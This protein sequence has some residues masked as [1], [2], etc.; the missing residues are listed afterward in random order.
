MPP[1]QGAEAADQRGQPGAQG[2]RGEA[3]GR[4][5]GAIAVPGVAVYSQADGLPP[6]NCATPAAA[7]QEFCPDSRE[8]SG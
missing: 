1:I 3:E 4:V 2:R 6:G 7:Q 8:L 5:P